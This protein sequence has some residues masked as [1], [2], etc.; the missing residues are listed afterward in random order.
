VNPTMNENGDHVG[1]VV[2]FLKSVGYTVRTL[3]ASRCIIVFD[4]KGGSQRKRKIYP[5]YKGK[6]RPKFRVNRTYK[7][8]LSAEDEHKSMKAQLARVVEYLELLPVSIMIHD[9]IEADDVIGYL[10]SNIFDK[11]TQNVN[12]VSTDKDFIQLVNDNVSIWSPTKKILLNKK[13]VIDE[14]Q[15]PAHNFLMYRILDGD[16]SDNI[17]G[18]PGVGI[19]SLIKRF[20]MITENETVGIDDIMQHANDNVG[21][22]KLYNTIIESEELMKRNYRLMQLNDADISG[23]TKL[24]IMSQS[25]EPINRLNQYEFTT[26]VIKDGI[27]EAFNDPHMWM[28]NNFMTMDIFAKRTHED[29]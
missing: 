29:E 12:I 5:D 16:V 10:A 11:P 8:M 20:P 24:K 26:M 18:V 3:E 21:K 23:T 22:I 6:K 9:N 17:P 14:Y 25:R 27:N 7:D 19:K 13:R 15:I 2:G 1:G 28:Q 4:G